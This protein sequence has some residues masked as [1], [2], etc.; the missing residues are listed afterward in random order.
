MAAW[1]FV[2]IICASAVVLL[3]QVNLESKSLRLPQAKAKGTFVEALKL[4]DIKGKTDTQD[5]CQRLN[6]CV[7][8][9]P[10]KVVGSFIQ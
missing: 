2:D 4:S 5:A 6:V 1:L 3:V 9:A 8:Y 10:H 7:C